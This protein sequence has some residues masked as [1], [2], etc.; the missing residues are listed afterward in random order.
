M[1]NQTLGM[2][3]CSTCSLKT[4]ITLSVSHA[5]DGFMLAPHA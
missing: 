1:A 5:G 4:K 2:K 3:I